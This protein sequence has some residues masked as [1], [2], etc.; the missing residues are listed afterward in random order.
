[1]RL[2]IQRLQTRIVLLALVIFLPVTG[3]VALSSYDAEQAALAQGEEDVQALADQIAADN[4]D[5]VE[6]TRLLLLTLARYPAIRDRDVEACH[7]LLADLLH[8][9]PRYASFF[10]VDGE[11]HISVCRSSPERAPINNAN[12]EWYQAAI[13]TGGFSVSEYRIGPV[14]NVPVIT[15]AQPIY[16]DD[17]ELDFLLAASLSLQWLNEFL[18]STDL[19]RSAII[20]LLDRNGVVLA[21]YPEEPSWIGQPYLNVPIR[22]TALSTLRGSIRG[23]SYAGTPYIFGFTALSTTSGQMHIVVGVSEYDVL[24]EAESLRTRNFLILAAVVAFGIGFAWLSAS[25]ITNPINSLT[26][27]IRGIAA[28]KLHA[29]AELTSDMAE[30]NA[31]ISAF[32]NMAQSLEAEDARQMEKLTQTNQRL[33]HEINERQQ[34]DDRNDILRLLSASLTEALTSSDVAVTVIQKGLMP[35]GCHLGAVALLDPK[36]KTLRIVARQYGDQITRVEPNDRVELQKLEIAGT[37][38]SNGEPLWVDSETS[39]QDRFSDFI[40]MGTAGTAPIRA[41][42]YLP[43]IV[44][45]KPI[46]CILAAFPTERI[47]DETLRRLLITITEYCAQTLERSRLFEEEA[48]AR[49]NAE[50]AMERVSRLQE[51]TAA[52][53]KAKTFEEVSELVITQGAAYIKAD[54]GAY[55]VIHKGKWLKRIYTFGFDNPEDSAHTL[56]EITDAFPGGYAAAHRVPL[57]F[58]TT[59]EMTA[60]CPAAAAFPM[61]AQCTSQAFLPLIAQDRVL[62]IA[63][64]AFRSPPLWTDADQQVMAAL[65]VQGAQAFERVRLA[66]E[67]EEA[68][69]VHE[70]QRLAR[71]LHDAVSQTLFSSALIA[72]GLPSQWSQKPEEA[73]KLVVELMK[74]NKSALAEMRTL[75]LEL[76]PE[77]VTRTALPTLIRQLI[78]AARG[79]RDIEASLEVHGGGDALP[80]DVHEMLYRI[81]Q[82]SINNILKHSQASEFRIHLIQEPQKAMLSVTDNGVGFDPERAVVGFGLEN[83][84]ERAE[85]VGAVVE[86]ESEGGRGTSVTVIWHA[87]HGDRAMNGGAPIKVN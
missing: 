22:E 6:S 74:L 54:M 37:V 40:K 61:V 38:F 18:S 44:G 46:G 28:G 43:L 71:D 50:R 70:R 33:R 87:P 27:A 75:L 51:M 58:M 30:L 69:K 34:A 47:L 5:Y 66:Q 72:E 3:L 78:D 21:R 85:S 86:I 2:R 52:L 19:P 24:E 7:S 57:W 67:A 82:E 20:T 80:S 62:G 35:V 64:F 13:R 11:T 49:R 39:Y 56:I 81:A 45:K 25:Y 68:A 76:R 79:R 9:L 26:A 73:S 60:M 48:E 1:M 84:R 10:V 14:T 31:L 83:M 17:G 65:M 55:C 4:Y 29:R 36:T 23:L 16:T 77:A 12:F 53:A 32:D 15:L 42:A 59:E 63:V 8:E 41:A